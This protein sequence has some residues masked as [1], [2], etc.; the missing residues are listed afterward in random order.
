MPDFTSGEWPVLE[1]AI[2]LHAQR[3]HLI[4]SNL[5]NADTPGYR[6]VKLPFEDVLREMVRRHGDPPLRT[7][8]PRHLGGTGSGQGRAPEVVVDTAG[9]GRD[10]NTVNSDQELVDL[11]VNQVQYNASVEV[12][13]RMFKLLDYAIDEGGK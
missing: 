7:T 4:V 8:Q 2:D 9:A 3:H 10:G 12:L 13:T 11:S 5:A 6:A 1:R